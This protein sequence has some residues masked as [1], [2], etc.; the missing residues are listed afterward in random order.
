MAQ[1]SDV[2]MRPQ[3]VFRP[4]V[5]ALVQRELL[6]LA[7]LIRRYPLGCAG[8]V[9][10]AIVIF[11]ALAAPLVTAYDPTQV[12][13][14]ER[15]QT[16]SWAHPM[17][18]DYEGRDILTRA[19]YGGRISLAVAVLSVLLGTTVGAFWG[20]ASAYVGGR[21]D[22]HSQRLLEVFMSF[23]PLV[24]AM[25]LVVGIGAGL[26][27]VVLAIG[28]TRLPFGVRVARSVALSVKELAYVESARAIG[29]SYWR[30][31]LRYI[32]PQCLASY[33]VLATA[34]LGVAIV[35]EASLGFLGVGIP[36]PTPTWGNMMG[37]AVANVLIP[38]WPIVVFPGL[39]ITIVVLAFNF[40]GDAVRDMFD[41]KLRGALG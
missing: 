32:A 34:Q 12:Q 38:H 3:M 26:W 36:Q 28:I 17:G 10:L 27:A 33:L 1:S 24:L 11:L 15:K 13:L 40:F 25:V 21:F 2:S 37:G 5:V 29:A 7:T 31:M 9:L 30:V 8:A 39:T 35:I 16:P 23:P 20:V 41:P 18:T 19:I 14:R 4:G 22:M 6:G